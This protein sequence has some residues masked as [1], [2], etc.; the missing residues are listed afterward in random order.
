MNFWQTDTIRLRAIEPSDAEILHR[1]NMDSE[2]ASGLD[3]LWPPTSLA[4]VEAFTAEES[5][6]KMEN[7]RCRWVIDKPDGTPVGAIDTHSCDLRNGTFSYGVD[8]AA[9]HRGNGYA[10]QAIRLVLRYYFDEL[11]YQKVTVLIH[12]NNPASLR[13][14]QK[15]GYQQEGCLRRM[16]FQHG[17]YI[18]VYYYGLTREEFHAQANN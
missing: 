10:G 5:K 13:L 9:E 15:L 12:A 3:F 4:S 7:D 16:L 11:R 8:I 18:D 17:E 14:H 2:R 6:R 1:W